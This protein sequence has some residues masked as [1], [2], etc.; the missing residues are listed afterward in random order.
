[1]VNQMGYSV[2]ATERV[3]RALRNRIRQGDYPPGAWLPSE[4]ALAVELDASRP[5]IRSALTELLAEGWISRA[6]GCRPRVSWPSR[7]AVTS[8]GRDRRRAGT[9][10]AIGVAMPQYP[11]Y[12]TAQAILRGIHDALRDQDSGPGGAAFSLHILD[13]KPRS[14]EG[15]IESIESERAALQSVEA[16]GLAGLIVWHLAGEATEADLQALDV[17]GV[18]VVYIDRRPPTLDCDYVGIDNEE[19][20]LQAVEHL[21][22]L[23]HRRIGYL[24]STERVSTVLERAKGFREAL[25]RLRLASDEELIFA[26][27]AECPLDLSLAAKYFSSVEAPPTAVVALNDLH[28]FEFMREIGKLG[29]H[30]PRDIS[31]VGVDDIESYSPHPAVLTSVHQPFHRMG[32]RAAELLMRRLVLEASSA[33]KTYHHLVLPTYLKVR[34]TTQPPPVRQPE[35]RKDATLA[36]P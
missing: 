27:D 26:T 31:V 10:L 30:V 35:L 3:A 2:A 8:G 21:A 23:G 25:K 20:M 33:P 13:T 11:S 15:P 34:S 7:Q 22:G 32:Q 19:A 5:I 17:R 6:P 4:R 36:I 12:A 24:S 18:P 14:G 9:P 16:N 29:W 1:M 28:A